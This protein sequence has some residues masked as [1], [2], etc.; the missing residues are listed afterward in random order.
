MDELRQAAKAGV[1]TR[2]EKEKDE[3]G[4]KVQLRAK[5][6]EEN[7]MRLLKACSQRRA[8]RRD[9]AI[10]SL[11]QRRIKERKYKDCIYAAICQKRVAAER[12]RSK[13][14]E[15]EKARACARIQQ[16]QRAVKSAHSQQEIERI[17]M[18]DKLE[19]RLLR[20]CLFLV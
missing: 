17:K 14:L 12:K 18:K 1:E 5:Q 19:D 3:L 15:E 16:V 13:L 20:V 2:F 10:Q 4:A 8:A 7:R 6:A 11:M 9:R